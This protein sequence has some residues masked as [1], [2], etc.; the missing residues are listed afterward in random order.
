MDT[1]LSKNYLLE[2]FP[3]LNFYTSN[4]AQNKLILY[5]WVNFR[6]YML[7]Y[8]FIYLSFQHCHSGLI[9]ALY[10]KYYIYFTILDTFPFL[11]KF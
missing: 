7:L 6:L 3:L 9:T 5:M 11:C 10:V 2:D 1:H 8:W 4:F